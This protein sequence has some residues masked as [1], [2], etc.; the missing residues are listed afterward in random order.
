M[1]FDN[2]FD[3]NLF[4]DFLNEKRNLADSSLYNYVKAV[5]KFLVERNDPLN[6][7]DYNRFIIKYAIKHRSAYYYSAL[8]AF[9]EYKI[10]DKGERVTMSE[11]L[12]QPDINRTIKCER[13][14]LEEEE[15]INIIN[16][17]RKQKHKI[18]ALIQDLT[19]VRVGDVLS[20][21]RGDIIPEIYDG[22]S[23]L[24]LIVEG[25]GKKRNVVFIHDDVVQVL[26]MNFLVSNYL[27]PDYYFLE[28]FDVCKHAQ[29][30][31]RRRMKS[32]YMRYYRDMKQAMYVSGVSHKDF[33]THDYRRCYARRVWTKYK[34][35]HI[36]QK[37][38][39]HANPATTMKYLNQ[40]G[41]QNID[42]HRD[43]QL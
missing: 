17:M 24:K 31:E 22:K 39:N 10:E 43:M 29:F 42:Y 14:Y 11:A 36:L 2:S 16:N 37:L 7:E 41:L 15:I 34:D 25:K 3:I 19:G 28:I 26:I 21:K 6:I 20:I 32:N 12:I 27:A 38:L 30:A 8:K 4:T 35:L 13:K 1:F 9:I 33:A 23:V 40:S 5:E 18:I